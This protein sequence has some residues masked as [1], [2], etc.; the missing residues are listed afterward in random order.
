MAEA[1]ITLPE[2]VPFRQTA[3]YTGAQ[4]ARGKD[5]T[6]VE[7]QPG[8]IVFRT[9]R[10]LPAHNGLTVAAAWQKG[11]VEPPTAA[12]LA[13]Y[14]LEDN[15]AL[16]VAMFGLAAAARATTPSPG[17]A[18]AA[19]RRSAPS[20]RCSGRRRGCRR[21]RRAMSTE[22]SFDDKCFTAAIINLGVKGPSAASSKATARSRSKSAAARP[23]SRPTK[24]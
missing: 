6:I 22:M 19:I 17:C 21:R 14:W 16:V 24:R 7:Q 9:T 8:R 2:Q 13:R 15:R 12:Q 10:P 1:R 18:S 20:S 23:R 3:F 4:G 11:V 5:A